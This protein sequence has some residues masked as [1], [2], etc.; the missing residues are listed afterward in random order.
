MAALNNADTW[1][2]LFTVGGVEGLPVETIARALIRQGVELDSPK[3][4]V[5][6]KGTRI[7]AYAAAESSTRVE[8]VLVRGQGPTG[9]HGWV[10]SKFLPPAPSAAAA[11]SSSS[12]SGGAT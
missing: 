12:S 6:P 10:S 5:I 3:G 11:P 8:R 1:I 7:F 4:E 2:S 9:I